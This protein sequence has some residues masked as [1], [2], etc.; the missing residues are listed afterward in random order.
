MKLAIIGATGFVGS[1]VLQEALD[2]GHSVTAIVRGTYKLP[3]HP[4]L[5]AKNADAYEASQ[6]AAA[7][8][9]HDAVISAFSGGW[10]NPDLRQDHVRGS[11]AI[12]A[13]VRESGVKRLLMVGG[14]GS[15]QVA[16][17]VDLVD[18]PQFPAEYKEGALGAR[19]ALDLLRAETELEWSLVSPPA[20]LEPGDR[21]GR[22]RVGGDQLLMDG[23]APAAISVEDLAVAILDE[24]EQPKHLRKR[25]TVAH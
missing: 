22:Y 18:T 24:I 14:A 19:A 1:R 20:L 7:V 2:R 6:V 25:F 4:S 8:K 12:Q 3:R 21:T 17:G 11:K 23:Q 5:T 9:G 16:P 13:G 15:L 10:T